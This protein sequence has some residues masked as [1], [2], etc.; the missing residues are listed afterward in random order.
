MPVEIV[1]TERTNEM[2]INPNAPPKTAV[3]GYNVGD[4]EADKDP[5]VIVIEDVVYCDG[6][7]ETDYAE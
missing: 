6:T 5:V 3:V 4:T 7:G 1:E 2:A